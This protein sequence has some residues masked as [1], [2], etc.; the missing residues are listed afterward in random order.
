MSSCEVNTVTDRD[1]RCCQLCVELVTEVSSR[2]CSHLRM[3]QPT[4][5]SE[6]QAHF[7]ITLVSVPHSPPP[8]CSLHLTFLC[9]LSSHM[10]GS[11]LFTQPLSL[12]LS[13]LHS[14]WFLCVRHPSKFNTLPFSLPHFLAQSSFSPPSPPTPSHL[15][16]LCLRVAPPLTPQELPLSTVSSSKLCFPQRWQEKN[17]S[18]KDQGPCLTPGAKCT[19]LKCQVDFQTCTGVMS[20]SSTF[21][22]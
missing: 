13:H 15:S 12:P 1:H 22:V 20:P 8:L 11:P 18:V 14:V 4:S 10:A 21:A 3:W 16:V 19:W 17:I 6:Q 5:L 7:S 2:C 9:S